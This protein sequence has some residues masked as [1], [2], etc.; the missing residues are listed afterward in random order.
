[1]TIQTIIKKTIE[2]LKNEGKHLTPDYYAEA[3]CTEA[4]LSG[5][6]IE[7]CSHLAKQID[8]LNK[9]FKDELSAYR[10]KS[11]NELAR[12]L[13]SRLNRTNPTHCSQVVEA[14]HETL[15]RVLQA[16]ALLHNKEVSQLAR[17]TL[18]MV[19][20]EPSLMEM[21][22]NRQLWSNFTSSYD[23]TFLQPLDPDAKFKKDDL[24]GMLEAY[25]VDPK[26]A[27][28]P[29]EEGIVEL[30]EL[31]ISSL[32]PSIS[33]TPDT[34]I[35]AL[36]KEIQADPSRL[37]RS[38]TKQMIKEA[39]ALRIALDKDSLR[40]M[41][42]SIDGVVNKLSNRLIEMIESSDSSTVQIQRIK[43]ELDEYKNS[44]LDNFNTAHKKLYTIAVAL[45]Q[46][47]QSLTKDLKSQNSEV[48]YLSRR[49]SDLEKEL[50]KAKEESREDFLTKIANKRA[51]DEFT[52]SKESEFDRHAHDFSIIIFDL[53]HFKKIND[54]YG[55]DAGDA[56][57]VA[58]A[59]ILKS[60]AREIDLVGRWGGEEFMAVL[61][62][63]SLEGAKSFA[64]KI[65]AKVS[66][67]R[68][69]YKNERIAVTTSA[70]VANR[71]DSASL[72]H[73]I[74]K[75]DDNLYRAK[76]EGRNRVIS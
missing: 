53:D 42:R 47:T 2:R 66:K 70:G 44:S 15:R 43:Q 33:A 61:N 39:I 1:M 63:T 16:T 35:D 19:N 5:F 75:A 51:L 30:A 45:E 23:D 74:K 6:K 14:Q 22:R 3:F 46:N 49:I 24:K 8:S 41:I 7:D 28:I 9:E 31:L 21:E 4:K 27:S 20:S 57:L 69:M 58:F 60:E 76:N 73:T 12:F 37:N 29:L 54:T 34:A 62:T 52:S 25:F 50:K 56:V 38:D 13:V 10:I 55:H 32:V 72:A 65:R 18:E 71:G 40:E 17:A 68:F 26:G 48:S 59:K 36:S 11:V 67:S 64:E